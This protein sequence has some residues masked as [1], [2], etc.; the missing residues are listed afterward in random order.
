VVVGA[1]PI[2]I[3]GS[4]VLDGVL[5]V[6]LA[7]GFTPVNRQTYTILTADNVTDLGLALAG[8]AAGQFRLA[9]GAGS[10]GLTAVP[11]PGAIG[12]LVFGAAMFGPIRRRRG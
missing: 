2:Q 3:G 5:D 11:E 8:E 12:L 7:D 4:A 1:A 6:S 9:V 10:V